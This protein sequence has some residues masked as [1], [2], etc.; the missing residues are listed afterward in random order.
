[1]STL[2][3][4]LL[5]LSSAN[6]TSRLPPRWGVA[7]ACVLAVLGLASIGSAA[8]QLWA[9]WV[10][11]ALKSI[12]MVVPLVSFLLILRVWR[13]L[14]W[15][16][17]GSWWG[18]AVLVATAL[19]VRFRDQAVL[20]L[21]L[22]PAWTLSLPPV[23]IVIFLYGLG[24][25]LLF[26]GPR[27]AR[28]SVFPLLLLL[29]VNPIPHVFNTFVD[30]PLQRASAHVAR[31]FAM[32]LGQPLSPDKM[33][34][35]FTPRFGMFIA[36]G[37]NGIRGAVTMGLIAAVAGYLYRFRWRAHL[38]VV[39]GAIALGYV[40]NLLRLCVL[41]LYYLVA[42]RVP[43]LQHKAENADYLIGAVLFFIAVY[44]LYT[45]IQ[46]L[47][48]KN[49]VGMLALP[50]V[51]AETAG[52]PAGFAL[53]A[54]SL[55]ALALFGLLGLAHGW[56]KT[57]VP[58]RLAAEEKV[59]GAFPETVGGY[60]R[61]RTWNEDLLSGTLLFHWAEYMPTGGGNPISIGVSP[62]LGAHDTMVCHT[63][64]GEDPLW[65]GGAEFATADGSAATLPVSFNA[66][67]F[68]DGATQYYEA[69]TICNEGACGEYGSPRA[70]FGVVYS[71][72][73]AG[74]MLNTSPARP[75]PILLRASMLDTTLPV[76][77]ARAQLGAELADFLRTL[78]LQSLTRSYR[79]E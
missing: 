12:G 77:A 5:P 6:R 24:V 35:M 23:S 43:S 2:S 11:D 20:L 30:L 61:V 47:G 42:L 74:A 50:V 70:H 18:L 46:R 78:D 39:L 59:Q 10:T 29:F 28:A 38:A 48:Q 60:Q 33:R 32:A 49:G 66:S 53:R 25:V 9:L 41:V 26:G 63:A 57:S 1:M 34:L 67:F 27:L 16:L 40:F 8:L 7:L 36:P 4:T 31:G 21:Y 65:H 55:A 56:H 69:T 58:A 51:Q 75:I 37:C 17:E 54:G 68:N 72:P 13:S 73:T 52:V 62:V 19:L 14:G 79:R 3:S 15:E 45:V 44:A 71:K 64:R 22:G 76:D